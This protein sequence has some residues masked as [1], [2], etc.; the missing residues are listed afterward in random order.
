MVEG[1]RRQRL[2][3]IS[4]GARKPDGLTSL[5][6]RVVEGRILLFLQQDRP[7]HQTEHS[8]FSQREIDVSEANGNRWIGFVRRRQQSS[9]KFTE[10]FRRHSRQHFFPA[11]EMTV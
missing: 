2:I 11:F 1:P 8:P 5:R 4:D 9:R 7:E 3:F 10:A 6:Y